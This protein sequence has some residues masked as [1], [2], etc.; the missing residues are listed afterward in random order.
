MICSTRSR[1]KFVKE[2]L[3]YSCAA[4]K[5]TYLYVYL[6]DA[7]RKERTRLRYDPHNEL[8]QERLQLLQDNKQKLLDEKN[9]DNVNKMLDKLY[10][11]LYYGLCNWQGSL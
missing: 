9:E 8:T 7:I 1:D 6:G 3:S 2:G 11:D 5:A 4:Y 10:K